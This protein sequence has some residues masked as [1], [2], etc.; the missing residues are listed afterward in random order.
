MAQPLWRGHSPPREHLRG[1]RT[2]AAWDV[3]SPDRRRD[4]ALY[5]V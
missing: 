4:H 5:F 3:C 1:G 2:L